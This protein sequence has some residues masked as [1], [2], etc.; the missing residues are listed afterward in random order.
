MFND[1]EARFHD[2]TKKE[3]D[4]KSP[5]SNPYVYGAISLLTSQGMTNLVKDPNFNALSQSLNLTC[6]VNY[7]ALA[8]VIQTSAEENMQKAAGISAGCVLPFSLHS[9]K[10]L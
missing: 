1:F 5:M 2:K 7:P 3:D 6:V 8:S 9:P 10:G 4:S